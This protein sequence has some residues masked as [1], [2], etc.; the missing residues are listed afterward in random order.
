MSTSLKRSRPAQGYYKYLNSL[1]VDERELRS[2][3][4]D[5]KRTVKA[6]PG[7]LEVGRDEGVYLVDRIISQ[8]VK[9]VNNKHYFAISI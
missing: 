9:Q 6:K 1:C 5:V 4:P 3:A 2:R 8:R 7:V